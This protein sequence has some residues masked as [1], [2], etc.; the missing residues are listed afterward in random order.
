[1]KAAEKESCRRK[2]A[3]KEKTVDKKWCDLKSGITP[4]CCYHFAERIDFTCSTSSRV[5]FSAG[6]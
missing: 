3:V 1:M 4:F 5:A 2:K 6:T